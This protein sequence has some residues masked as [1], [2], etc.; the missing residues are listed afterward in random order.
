[1]KGTLRC[2]ELELDPVTNDVTAVLATTHM[3]VCVLYERGTEPALG[4]ELK[5]EIAEPR[6]LVSESS[7]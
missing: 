7:E 2:L 4:E 3:K 1:M 6:A 5:F